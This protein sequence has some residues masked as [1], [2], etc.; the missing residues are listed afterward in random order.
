MQLFSDDQHVLRTNGRARVV[1]FPTT[2][3]CVRM[4]HAAKIGVRTI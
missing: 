2:E 4:T 1:A 3:A